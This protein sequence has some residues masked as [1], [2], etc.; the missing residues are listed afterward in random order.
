MN[1][2]GKKKIPQFNLNWIVKFAKSRYVFE[3]ETIQQISVTSIFSPMIYAITFTHYNG[4]KASCLFFKT[5]FDGEDSKVLDI[6][7]DPAIDHRITAYFIFST[8]N[9]PP[10]QV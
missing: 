6:I 9:H 8:L 5:E 7:S 1:S 3:N 4:S 2:F 10:R